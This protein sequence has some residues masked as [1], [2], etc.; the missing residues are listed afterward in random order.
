[1][2]CQP[3]AAFASRVGSY[4][5]THSVMRS[6]SY[7]PHPSLKTTHITIDG[8]FQKASIIALSSSSNCA[9]PSAAGSGPASPFSC[10]RPLLPLGMSCQTRTPSRS[11]Q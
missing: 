4:I 6:V 2:S 8:W 5:L 9:G 1:L 7:W 11:A 3:L 10:S